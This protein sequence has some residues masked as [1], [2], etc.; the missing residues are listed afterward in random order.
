MICVET[1]LQASDMEGGTSQ[2][3][4]MGVA[5]LEKLSIRAT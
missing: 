4:V 5:Q 2:N 1:L 3:E